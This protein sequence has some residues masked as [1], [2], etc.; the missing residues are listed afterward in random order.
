MVML[1]CIGSQIYL[2]WPDHVICKKF[3]D[4]L[5]TAKAQGGHQDHKAW[6]VNFDL[7][8][9]SSNRG[10]GHI[11][12]MEFSRQDY[13]VDCHFLLH[14]TT[15]CHNC[16]LWPVCFGWPWMPWLIASL[17]YASLFAS[18]SLWSIKGTL[19][20]GKTEGKK[21]R[22]LQSGRWLYSITESMGMNLSKLREI[23]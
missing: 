5:L 15:F 4:L 8:N 22:S 17:S 1:T 2:I 18:T 6:H 23:A 11:L 13:G 9:S 21:R 12:F 14:W 7:S 10:S 3:S 19:M 16:S 20:L